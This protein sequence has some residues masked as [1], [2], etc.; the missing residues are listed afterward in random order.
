MRLLFLVDAVPHA[1]STGGY[2]IIYQRI[3]RLARRGHQIAVLCFG[4]PAGDDAVADLRSQV[5]WLRILPRPSQ[6][7]RAILSRSLRWRRPWWFARS[8]SAQ[9]QRTVGDMVE[10]LR[11]HAAIAEF[12]PMGQYFLMNPYLS[13]V[14]RVVS[15]HGSPWFGCHH[16]LKVVRPGGYAWLTLVCRMPGMKKFEFAVYRNADW[17]TTLTPAERYWLLTVAPGLDISVVPAGVDISHFRPRDASQTEEAVMFMGRFSDETNVDA[18]V[19]FANSIWPHLTRRRPEARFYV[20][21]PKPPPVLRSLPRRDPR[22]VVTGYVQDVRPF[23]RRSRAFVCPIRIGSGMRMKVLEAMASGVPVVSTVLGM[24]GIPAEPGGNCFLNDCPQRIASYLEL[25]LSDL[26][27][28]R[29]MGAAARRTVEA[30]FDWEKITDTF[31]AG[32]QRLLPTPSA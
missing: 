2:Q 27:L 3:T 22:I 8:F 31:E 4:D 19:W 21:G 12:T 17:V 32:L 1:G 29:E 11:F 16:A 25:L 18:V 20:V 14:R 13:A 10:Q 15:C 28:N 26:D 6:T 23:F 24:E 7:R 9:M 5:K 30:S